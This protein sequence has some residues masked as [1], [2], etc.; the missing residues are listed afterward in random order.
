[1]KQ[2][3][4]R[5]RRSTKPLA[6]ETEYTVWSINDAENEPYLNE[7]HGKYSSFPKAKAQVRNLEEG[8]YVILENRQVAAVTVRKET[9]VKTVVKVEKTVG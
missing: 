4:R 3:K 9:S 5:S 6:W 2:K 1:M 8:D 7:A